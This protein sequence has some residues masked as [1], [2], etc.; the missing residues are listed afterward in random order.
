MESH[1]GRIEYVL[2][3]SEH[4]CLEDLAADGPMSFSAMEINFLNNNAAAYGYERVGDAW[5]YAKGG[6]G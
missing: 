2:D 5:V 3:H 6:K 1:V 4:S